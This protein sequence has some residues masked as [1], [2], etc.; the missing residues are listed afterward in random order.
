ME[1]MD[2]VFGVVFKEVLE[3]L[4]SGV[5]RSSV[6]SGWQVTA[7]ITMEIHSSLLPGRRVGRK[8]P[9]ILFYHGHS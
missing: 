8:F 3:L 7:Y 6:L 2:T 9:S 5:L 4:D 1:P